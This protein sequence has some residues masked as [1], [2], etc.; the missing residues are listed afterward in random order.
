VDLA[1]LI[2]VAEQSDSRFLASLGMTI[3]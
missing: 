1:A 3:N 2:L